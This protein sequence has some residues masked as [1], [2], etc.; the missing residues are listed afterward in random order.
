MILIFFLIN[1]M[2]ELLLFS[3]IVAHIMSIASKA[4]DKMHGV[5]NVATDIIKLK[6]TMLN[7]L[8]YCR[9]L[10]DIILVRFGYHEK[11]GKIFYITRNTIIFYPMFH[12][13]DCCIIITTIS[14]KWR[15]IYRPPSRQSSER[16]IKCTSATLLIGIKEEFFST[17]SWLTRS[18]GH[19]SQKSKEKKSLIIRSLFEGGCN[20]QNLM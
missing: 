5:L 18:R 9:L 4:S 2:L 7:Y 10:V 17:I 11:I 13:S 6:E 16:T 3:E 8:L 14:A 1:L 19:V 15:R 12:S 20:R